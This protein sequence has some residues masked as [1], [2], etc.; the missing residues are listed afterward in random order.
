MFPRIDVDT[1]T[2]T[3]T[4]THNYRYADVLDGVG[5]PMWEQFVDSM[6]YAFLEARENSTA[7]FCLVETMMVRSKFPCFQ[8]MGRTALKMFKDRFRLDLKDSEV[9]AFVSDLASRSLRSRGTYIYD[10]FQRK[11]NGI[12]V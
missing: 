3:H 1:H 8:A 12:A 7:L 6:C 2:H 9:R 4:H 10:L 5:S 11:S